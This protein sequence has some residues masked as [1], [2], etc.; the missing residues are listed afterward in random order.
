MKKW[1]GFFLLGLITCGF[2]GNDSYRRVINQSFTT[3]EVL[4]YRVHYGIINAGEAT[5][6]VS[7]SLYKI[8]NRVC[9]KVNVFGRTTGVFDWTLRIRDTWRSYI[10][11]AAFVPQR[12]YINIQEGRYRKEETVYFDH[13]KHTVQ[14]VEVNSDTKEFKIPPNVQDIVSGYYYLRTIDFDQLK[15]GTVIN[16]DAFFDDEF[17]DF[18]IKYL[19][20]EEI[21]TKFGKINTVV[22]T[23]IMPTNSLFKGENP[24]RVWI[25]DD[26]NKVP[27]KVEADMVVGAVAMDLKGYKGLRKDLT[28]N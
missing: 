3:G 1:S 24:I 18:K 5:I 15:E 27:L 21:K 17:Y 28:F 8:N 14:S 9:Y 11:T 25:S 16:V 6:D 13:T 12:F 26:T 7:P 10:D 20:K 22:I 19:G 2:V 4:E 23:P